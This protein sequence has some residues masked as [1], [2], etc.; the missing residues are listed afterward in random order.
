M[1]GLLIMLLLES[2]AWRKVVAARE[3]YLDARAV[4]QEAGI[5][6]EA[7]LGARWPR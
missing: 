4:A 6:V 1:R 3:A 5:D 7:A 2:I